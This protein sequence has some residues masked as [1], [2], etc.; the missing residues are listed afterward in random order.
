MDRLPGILKEDCY[1]DAEVFKR[2]YDDATVLN[3][4]KKI[5]NFYLSRNIT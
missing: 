5:T 3:V 2:L 4:G 1:P